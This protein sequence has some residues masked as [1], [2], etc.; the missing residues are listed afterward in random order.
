MFDGSLHVFDRLTEIAGFHLMPHVQQLLLTA[1][2]ARLHGS[3]SLDGRLVVV[4]ANIVQG[5]LHSLARRLR[6]SND[7]RQHCAVRRVDASALD[8]ATHSI[9]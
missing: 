8:A 4:D 1:T 5:R 7:E 9:D 2:D 6:V 3:Q